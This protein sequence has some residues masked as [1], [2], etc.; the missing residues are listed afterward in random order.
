MNQV[1]VCSVRILVT[2]IHTHS[3]TYKAKMKVPP[4]VW[5]FM[6][7]QASVVMNFLALVLG[8]FV[9]G[10]GRKCSNSRTD[11]PTDSQTKY[12]NPCHACVPKVNK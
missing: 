10:C 9:E 4:R 12:F 8:R 3:D 6:V 1:I 7:K 5:V 2:D 11:G